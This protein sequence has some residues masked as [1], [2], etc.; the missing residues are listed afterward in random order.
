MLPGVGQNFR[1][2]D[3]G[4]RRNRTP[5]SHPYMAAPQREEQSKGLSAVPTLEALLAQLQA[6]GGSRSHKRVSLELDSGL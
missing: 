6:R 4:E 3:K 1:K 2:E 5:E